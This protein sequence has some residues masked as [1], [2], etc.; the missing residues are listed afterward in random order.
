MRIITKETISRLLD[1]D[2]CRELVEGAMKATAAG[3]TTQPPRW[4]MPLPMQQGAVLGLMP[5][6]LHDGGW[7]GAK[8]TG[9]YPENHRAGLP[10]HQGLIILFEP[11]T[12]RP[13][14]AVDGGEITAMRT[15]AA[16]A[17][18]TRALANPDAA[19]LTLLGYG[20]QAKRH[21][22]AIRKI[23]PISHVR[24]WGRDA[25][26]VD[27]FAAAQAES[28]GL[29]IRRHATVESAADGADII[30]T[31]SA[32]ATPILDAN[33]VK[34]GMHLN[35]VGSSARDYVEIDPRCL[36]DARVYVDQTAAAWT[37]GGDLN[38][39][40]EHQYITAD[41]IS[42]IGTVLNGAPGRVSADD[43]TIYKSVGIPAQDLVCAAF[44]YEEATRLGLGVS[45]DLSG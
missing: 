13:I 21:L 10:S 17:V 35:V 36:Q 28:T 16:S 26:R 11:Q 31:V 5:G 15:A 38:Q 2:T 23:R 45:A 42:E 41:S 4:M 6:H 9:V 25:A 14:A 19:N 1:D 33:W 43:I 27:A 37:L 7:F 18:A 39:A 29:D 44:L 40:L 3:K 20:E 8:I 34:P 24:I 32:A 12:G 30:C 22:H